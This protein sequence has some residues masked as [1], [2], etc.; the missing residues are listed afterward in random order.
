M[1]ISHYKNVNAVFVTLSLTLSAIKLQ[2]KNMLLAWHTHK[3]GVWSVRQTTGQTEHAKGV[4][5]DKCMCEYR[6]DSW[7]W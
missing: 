4:K 3:H 7:K 5:N 6:G 2:L 1:H